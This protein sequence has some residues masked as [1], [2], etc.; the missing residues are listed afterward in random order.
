MNRL[1]MDYVLLKDSIKIDSSHM[2]VVYKQ[3]DGMIER[4][5]VPGPTIFIPSAYEW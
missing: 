1:E 4:R 5:I 3:L 2:V